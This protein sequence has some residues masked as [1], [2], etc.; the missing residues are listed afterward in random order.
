MLAFD[1]PRSWLPV[2]LQY[3]LPLVFWRPAIDLLFNCASIIEFS[4][5]IPLVEVMLTTAK[6]GASHSSFSFAIVG[7]TSTGD[8]GAP[9]IFRAS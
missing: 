5:S 1:L 8:V 3:V 4:Y 7:L 9:F 6:L 2:M